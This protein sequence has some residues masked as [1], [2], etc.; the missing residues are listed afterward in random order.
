MTAN[1]VAPGAAIGILGGGQLARMLALAAARLGLRTVILAPEQEAPATEVCWRHIRADYT[2]EAA[3]NE[4]CATAAVV[5][6]E[7]ENVPIEAA[8]AIVKRVFVAPAPL[9]FAVKQ[10]RLLEKRFLTGLGIAVAPYAD[11]THT[12]DLG[13]AARLGF[14]AVLKTRRLGYDGKGQAKVGSA[15]ELEQAWKIGGKVPSCLEAFIKFDG[16]ASI[17][18]ARGKQGEFA[19]YDLTENTH[20]A[21][22]VLKESRVPA[23]WNGALEKRAQGIAEQIAVALDYV[24]VLAV[25]FFVVGEKL[26]VNEIAPRVHNSGHWTIDGA[27]TSQFE[28]HC[29]AICGWPLGSTARHSD[30]VMT[31]LI[32]DE[33]SEWASLAR[34]PGAHLH[35][36]GKREARPGRKMGHVTRT[37]PLGSLST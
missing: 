34:E 32:G 24:G 23:H 14:P 29:R 3:L 37:S 7:W 8:N 36:Y 13:A 21:D 25:E 11:V 27:M 28:Q 31:N 1:V 9:A 33:V 18:C 12:E 2:D 4:L 10:D 26:L 35:L 5:T 19:T 22:H 6:H 15:A 17:V 16:E 30:V 20:T